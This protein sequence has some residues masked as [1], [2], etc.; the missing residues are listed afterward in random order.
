M[1]LRILVATRIYA[2][3]TGAAAFRLAAM[4]KAL[5]G[6]GHHVTVLTTSS[7]G[8]KRSSP[9]VRRWPVLRD[10]SGAVRGYVQYA[11]F[12]IPLFLRL[13]TAPAFD[14]VVVEPPP[15]TGVVVR[16]AT[17]LRRRPFVYFAADV[18]S[19]AAEGIG[20]SPAVVR[21]L[22][23]IERWTL[24]RARRILTV[25]EGVSTAVAALV[26]QSDRIV[27]VG[28][29]VDTDQFTNDGPAGPDDGGRYFV[30]AG[31]MSEIQG[32]GVFVDAFISIAAE[33]P[34]VRLVMYGQG[35]ELDELRARAEAVSAP[36][37]F[38]GTVDGDQISTALR[39]SV[40][41]LASVRP[42]RGYDFAFATKALVSLSCGT[43]V[44]Y[45]GV[46]P[47]KNII[48]D[49]NL[50]V[51]VDWEPAAVAAAMRD[52]LAW[53]QDAAERQRISGWV[54]QNYSLRSVGARAAEAIEAAASE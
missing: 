6:R 40:A 36:I 45:A 19:V 3:E 26:G 31:T 17:A 13:L 24:S 9:S 5:Q 47:L 52:A 11:S 51:S 2:P 49:E 18:S 48:A 43:P 28:T 15:T 8:A 38:R 1:P 35:V 33:Y 23:A 53:P 29:G 21:V 4:V 39:G 44:I 20:V 37:D 54:Q 22:R 14:L 42:S 30:Y 32:A 50:G 25:S 34:D 7:P 41:G 46:G 27:N 12:D 16:V 10:K